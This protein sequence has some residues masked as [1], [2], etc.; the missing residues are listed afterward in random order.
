MFGN[1][2]RVLKKVDNYH[3]LS[4][5][6]ASFTSLKQPHLE[7]LSASNLHPKVIQENE[8]ERDLE[9]YSREA[10]SVRAKHLKIQSMNDLK[11]AVERSA[12][13]SDKSFNNQY[14]HK[15]LVQEVKR[16]PENMTN[17]LKLDQVLPVS[18][19]YSQKAVSTA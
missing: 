2:A 15:M 11:K 13:G 7:A 8:F 14:L 5:N 1:K 3:Q 16:A 12:T 9:V 10:K 17:F 18:K 4:N 19:N 6:V